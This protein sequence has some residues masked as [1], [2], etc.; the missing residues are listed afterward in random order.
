M[1]RVLF[2]L[3][4]VVMAMLIVGCSGD[5]GKNKNKISVNIESEPKTMDPQLLVDHSA[6]VMSNSLWEGLTRIGK[7]GKIAPAAAEKWDVNGNV[8]TFYIRDNAKWSNGDKVTANDFYFAIK[9]AI[10]P[11]TASEYAYMTYYIKNAQKYN[12]S[13]LNDFSQVGVKVID[14]KRLEITLETPVPYFAAVLAFPTYFPCNQKFFEGVGQGYSLEADQ[15]IYNGPWKMVQWQHD[16]KMV[17][18]KNE[19]YWNKNEIKLD[20]IEYLMIENATTAA[21]MY[22]NNKIDISV[23]QTDQIK[24]FKDSPEYTTY[25]DGSVW[26]YEFNIK[27]KYFKNGK[28]RRAM[29]LA[30]DR[31]LL[32]NQ[33]LED[34][35]TAALAMVPPGIPGKNRSF[36]EDYGTKYFENN[37]V[38]EA[39]KLLEEGLKEIGEKEIR[40]T[41]LCDTRTERKKV[42]VF[43]QEQLKKNLGVTVDLEP[44]SFQIRLQKMQS[45][46]FDVVASGWSPDYN[47]PMTFLDMWTTNNGNNH[48]LWSNKKY[49][50]L[51]NKALVTEDNSARMDVMAEAGKLL[52]EE[53][54]VGPIYYRN[55]NALIRSNVK[56]VKISSVGPEYDFYWASIS[57]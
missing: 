25:S 19:N 49:D 3:T 42:A 11:K 26:Y 51:I 46:D 56:D 15:A 8:W 52:M 4:V 36:R 18:T 23:I 40:F 55:R 7:D 31:E 43:I 2:C 20:G 22:K 29:T 45:H 14:E 50:E 37:N 32:V 21:N 48:T 53:M 41:L 28:I 57:K 10:E 47:D 6:I 5:G 39:K 24:Q 1:K 27:N 12:E 54:P 30:L 16:N 33:V 13:K 9:R 17:L 38:A 34:G 44:V 35:S